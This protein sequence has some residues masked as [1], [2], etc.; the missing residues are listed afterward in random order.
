METCLP[1]SFTVETCLPPSLAASSYAPVPSEAPLMPEAELHPT[2]P[3]PLQEEAPTVESSPPPTAIN[4]DDDYR[5]LEL[6]HYIVTEM[7]P[8]L[9]IPSPTANIDR[10]REALDRDANLRVSKSLGK[11]VMVIVRAAVHVCHATSGMCLLGIQY[12]AMSPVLHQL[13]LHALKDY[14][15]TMHY[16]PATVMPKE[17]LPAMGNFFPFYY[18][19]IFN[20]YIRFVRVMQEALLDI[21][22]AADPMVSFMTT[23]SGWDVYFRGDSRHLSLCQLLQDTMHPYVRISPSEANIKHVSHVTVSMVRISCITRM[24]YLLM[25]TLLDPVMHTDTLHP[26]VARVLDTTPA[27][28]VVPGVEHNTRLGTLQARLHQLCDTFRVPVF[29][30]TEKH[31]HAFHIMDEYERATVMLDVLSVYR[32]CTATWHTRK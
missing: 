31:M 23:Q 20:V 2:S 15:E 10:L 18:R 32:M 11:N 26:L 5:L 4:R 17:R 16:V 3:P 22:T 25:V 8:M 27:P 12:R 14:S 21:V 19:H 28:P 29:L 13:V 9:N 30:I 1:P 24:R 7:V 6:L